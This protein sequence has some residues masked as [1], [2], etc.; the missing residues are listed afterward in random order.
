MV[1]GHGIHSGGTRTMF[2][3]S[4]K[5]VTSTHTAGS[6]Q[7]IASATMSAVSA[8]RQ[9]RAV[10][11]M[12]ASVLGVAAQQPELE[13]RESKNDHEEHP[14]HRRGGAEVEEVLEGR[15][16]E[17]L[18]DGSRRVARTAVGQDEHLAEDLERADD[19]GDEHE[20]EHRPEQRHRDRPEAAPA[21]GA[22][23]RGRLVEL[24]RNVLESGQID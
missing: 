24:A 6:S 9:T 20:Q 3:V 16:V 7:A 10:R 11:L 8:A 4:F 19:V 15:L 18:D 5:E 14:R 1:A 12:R 2:S 17:V 22:V 13:Q 23:D 21:T